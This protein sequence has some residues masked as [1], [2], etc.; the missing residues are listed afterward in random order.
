VTHA[1]PAPD[2]LL[3]GAQQLGVAPG[4]CWYVG[5]STWDMEAARAAGMRAI[6]ITSGVIPADA[7]ISSGAD[8]VLRHL[9]ELRAELERAGSAE[10]ISQPARS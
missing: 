4:A 1:K 5:D 3:A 9:G 8:I 6:G 10:A 2:L 7:L